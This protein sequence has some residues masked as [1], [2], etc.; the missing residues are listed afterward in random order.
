MPAD[1]PAREVW[2]QGIYVMDGTDSSG[3]NCSPE[4]IALRTK[5]DELQAIIDAIPVYIFY[6]DNNNRIIDLNRTAAV[7]IGLP[8]QEIRGRQTEDFFPPED[9]ADFLLDDRK[10]IESGLPKLGIVECYET[11]EQGGRRHIRTDK[12]PLRGP[13]GEFDRLVAIASDTTEAVES[14][15]RAEYAEQRLSLAMKT[16]GIG[17]WDWNMQTGEVYFSDTFFTMHGYDVGE[18]APHIET[19]ERLCHPNDLPEAM[20]D[21]TRHSEGKTAI[22]V[23]EQR[24]RQ[25]SGDWHWVR[26]VGEIVERDAND[27]PMRMLGVHID[28]QEIREAKLKAEAASRAKSDFLAN[29]SH[30]IRTPMTAILGYAD[31]FASEYES[32]KDPAEL[33]AMAKTIQSN[34][35]H[36]LSVINDILD[37]SKIEAGYL[38]LEQIETSPMFLVEEVAS[39][40]RPLAVSKGLNLT[41]NYNSEIPSSVLADPTRVKQVL[42]NLVG[43]AIKFTET[44]SV[45]LG[46]AYDKINST[47]CLEVS[48]TGIG[49]PPE[50]VERLENNEPFTQADPSTTRRYGGSGLGIKITHALVRMM[51]GSIHIASKLSAGTTI[52]LEMTTQVSPGAEWIDPET[53]HLLM[54]RSADTDRASQHLKQDMPLKGISILLAE[55]GH[56][57]Q[58]LITHFL[59]QAGARVA[60]ANT[61]VEAIARAQSHKPR[62][63]LMDMQMP[64]MD[65]Y[66]ATRTLRESGCGLPIIALTA[67]A[68]DGDRERCLEAGCTDYLAK[69]LDRKEL[70]RL[71]VEYAWTADTRD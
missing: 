66:Q 40:M 57:N 22:Y 38:H 16:G 58:R 7:S 62:V 31:L 54:Q 36:L 55:D 63:I 8:A 27:H 11:G 15:E 18:L 32:F 20:S 4:I 44:G 56:D 9:S 12:I 51:H 46:I 42:L 45:S 17:L 10:V 64:E 29:M 52:S 41:V 5:V 68:M 21:V 48:D 69:P 3:H 35:T 24:I 25:K 6:K 26:V 37:V 34:A 53:T 60:I 30:E 39:L 65:G 61:G 70:I 50:L 47:I 13:S 19:W 67:H 33:R 59:E 71:C 43:N 49:M 14:L 2:F 23:N 28:I 1:S